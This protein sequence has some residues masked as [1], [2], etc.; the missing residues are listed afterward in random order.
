MTDKK[1]RRST[2]QRQVILSELRQLTS[3]PTAMDL[4][5]IARRRLPKLSLATVYRNLA[6]L[7]ADGAILKLESS[8]A[9]TRFDGNPARHCHVRCIRCGRVDDVHETVADA[10]LASFTKLDGYDI[11]SHQLE[12]VGVCPA[13]R[14]LPGRDDGQA[15]TP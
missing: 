1:A 14:D 10:G 6:L 12:F 5:E 8:G 4:F 11:I 2:R 13:C 9:E 15:V 3:H 7:A